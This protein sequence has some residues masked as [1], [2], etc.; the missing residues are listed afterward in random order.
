[1]SL[2]P[3]DDVHDDLDL[4][5]LNCFGLFDL[6]GHLADPRILREANHLSVRSENNVSSTHNFLI[7][8]MARHMRMLESTLRYPNRYRTNTDTASSGT[9]RRL[10][11]ARLDHMASLGLRISTI[12]TSD[13]HAA[14]PLHMHWRTTSSPRC[15][16]SNTLQH[17]L[18]P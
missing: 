8:G 11:L 9:S 15:V 17:T 2:S 13:S 12:A 5:R 1:V 18:S 16:L 7:T 6:H 4:I 3:N 14:C 10:R